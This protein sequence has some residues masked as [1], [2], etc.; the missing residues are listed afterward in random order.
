VRRKTVTGGDTLIRKL[1]FAVLF[2]FASTPAVRAETVVEHDV[3]YGKAAGQELLLDVYRPAEKPKKPRA[4]V[5]IVHGGGWSSGSKAHF[6]YVANL[7]AKAGLV[8]YSIDYRLVKNDA[9]PAKANHWPAQLDDAQ[10][11]VR[12]IRKNAEKYE[13]DPER[14][15]A[16]GSSAG[17]HIAAFLGMSDTRDDSDAALQGI[18]SRVKCVVS[19]CGPTD[20]TDDFSKKVADGQWAD[21]VI[22]G[23]LGG[24]DKTRSDLARKA[25]PL[26]LVDAKS[27]P[28]LIVHGKKDPIVP[29][30]H[31]ERLDAAL[32]K[33]G[34]ESK[35]VLHEGG[36]NLD[37][38]LTVYILA[39]ELAKF[40]RKHLG[41]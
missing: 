4:A 12:W 10:R 13:I 5:L 41:E 25:S 9:N 34:V 21:G 3:P 8:A 14:V 28:F 19:I 39:D 23:L 6:H 30:D 11:A 36:H 31:S 33:A 16:L 15:A 17:G 35:L 27:A 38:P 22:R 32:R 2:L 40:L 37:G 1:G 26:F 24:T 20:L 18:S 29:V 7:I